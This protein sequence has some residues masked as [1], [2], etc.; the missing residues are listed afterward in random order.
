M[1]KTGIWR[2]SE[3]TTNLHEADDI[4]KNVM[5]LPENCIEKLLNQLK[6]KLLVEMHNITRSDI[7]FE[8]RHVEVKEGLKRLEKM[9][10]TENSYSGEI[11]EMFERIN[12]IEEGKR[13]E[14]LFRV[15]E[16]ER[17]LYQVNIQ[18]LKR[19]KN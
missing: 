19:F 17:E 7:L 5:A 6:L 1:I 4:L 13:E 2:T 15:K 16:I 11:Y 14:M 3:P 12:K 18:R 9:I 8:V 10:Q